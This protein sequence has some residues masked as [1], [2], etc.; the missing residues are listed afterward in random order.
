MCC[1]ET[2]LSFVLSMVR[3]TI[4]HNFTGYALDAVGSR[5]TALAVADGRIVAAGSES[6]VRETLRSFAAEATRIDL[7]GRTVVP[8]LI[9][10]HN[11]L[12]QYGIEATRSADLTGCKSISEMLD[13]LRSFRAAHPDLPWLLG[14]RFD[15]ELFAEGRWPTRQ[16]LDTIGS[17]IPI[18]VSRVCLHA[19]VANSAA[20]APLRNRLGAD[21]LKTGLLTEDAADALWRLIPSPSLHDV[22]RAALWAMKEARRAGLTG[23][24]CIVS[25]VE[26]LEAIRALHD[27]G[28]LPIRLTLQC[29]YGMM[30]RLVSDGLKTGSGNEKL[31]IGALKVFMDGS[32]GARTAALKLPYADDPENSGVP[33]RNERDLAALLREMQAHGFQAA[34]HAIGDLAVECAASG[35]ESAMRF[36]NQGNRLRHRIEHAS[37]MSPRLVAEIARL[38][39][40][41]CVQP[42]FIITDFW[43]P[44]RVGPERYRWAYPFKTMLDAGIVLAMGSDCPVERLDAV[45][46]IGRAVNREPHSSAERL[47]VEQTLRAYSFGSAYAGFGEQ[48]LGSL[49]VGKLADFTVFAPDV[50]EADPSEIGGAR[51]EA[52]FVGGQVE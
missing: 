13:R 24:H 51:V 2:D 21:Q 47:T 23:V 41:V 49:E 33:F 48:V 42:Q 27:E 30:D 29:P 7:G 36:G 46:L 17:D 8:G 25:G 37:I 45:E 11:H 34:I 3:M 18:M 31:K 5:I 16:D 38:G 4:F 1:G 52:T 15:Q 12:V 43:T 35:I 39:V 28:S 6:F 14:R 44:R 20:L 10:A 32:L 40:P 50:L 9:D 26:E 19:I 22:K